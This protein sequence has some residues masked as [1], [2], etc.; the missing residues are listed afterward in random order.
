VREEGVRRHR[1]LEGGVRGHIV[2]EEVVR[3]HRVLEGGVRGHREREGGGSRRTGVKVRAAA[4]ARRTWMSRN[5]DSYHLVASCASRSTAAIPE[6][7][8]CSS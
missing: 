6:T 2:C 5:P 8:R 3:G 1:V 4:A 7:K